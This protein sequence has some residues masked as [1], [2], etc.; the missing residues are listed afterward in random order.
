MFVLN[1]E[2]E[3]NIAFLFRSGSERSHKL[4]TTTHSQGCPTSPSLPNF[5]NVTQSIMVCEE[6]PMNGNDASVCVESVSESNVG[7]SASECPHALLS[8]VNTDSVTNIRIDD[9]PV[10][11]FPTNTNSGDYNPVH[12]ESQASGTSVESESYTDTVEASILEGYVGIEAKEPN[13]AAQPNKPVLRK[14][15]QPSRLNIR[16]NQSNCSKNGVEFLRSDLPTHLTDDSDSDNPIEY[17]DSESYPRIPTTSSRSSDDD[18]EVPIGGLAAKVARRDTLALRLEA[19]PCKDDISGQTADDRRTLMHNASIKLA[20]KL[21]ERPSAEELENR[22]ILRSPAVKTM[23]EKRKLLLRKLSF[24]PTIAQLKEQQIIQF[25]DY[26]E[27]TQAQAYD[28]KADKPWTRLTSMDKAL[29]RK[30]LNDFKATE[31]DVHEESRIFTR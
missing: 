22:N 9:V 20:R 14:P 21:S 25:N 18:E 1:I 11:L 5:R 27:V 6:L 24:R 29:I 2:A 17:R 26:V 31:M 7:E 19:P 23:E 8:G 13:L 15:G 4:T 10:L 28:R 12:C 16:K 30:E 3:L